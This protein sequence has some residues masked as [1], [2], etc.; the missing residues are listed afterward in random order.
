MSSS[1]S[2]PQDNSRGSKRV[3]RIL[4]ASSDDEN[5]SDYSAESPQTPQTPQKRTVECSR[6]N[7]TIPQTLVTLCAAKQQL[8]TYE[9]LVKVKDD[10]I[11]KKKTE[12]EELDAKLRETIG[13]LEVERANRMCFEEDISSLEQEL[14]EFEAEHGNLKKEMNKWVRKTLKLHYLFEQMERVGLSSSKDIL[15]MYHDIKIPEQVRGSEEIF[16]KLKTGAVGGPDNV[17]YTNYQQ[18]LD[19]Y[20]ADLGP[21]VGEEEPDAQ[22]EPE[23]DPDPEPEPDL[24]LDDDLELSEDEDEDDDI[25]VVMGADFT[26]EAE[27]PQ[28]PMVIPVESIIAAASTN[29]VIPAPEPHDIE[30]I[31]E[32]S[33]SL[34]YGGDVQAAMRDQNRD[35]IRKIFAA[36]EANNTEPHIEKVVIYAEE[37]DAAIKIQTAWRCSRFFISR[38]P[39]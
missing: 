18:D 23:P 7:E 32:A 29:I 38:G 1:H 4:F 10:E 15:N 37:I 20:G 31:T 34:P 35:A 26:E 33:A 17:E 13:E 6:L 27:I 19:H 3:R 22:S 11:A 2:L 21:R 24:D 36:R 39:E 14:G 25:G 12:I 28:I 8:E 5:D 30:D 16:Q 9:S